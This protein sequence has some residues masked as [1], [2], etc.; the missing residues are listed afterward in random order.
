M[1]IALDTNVLLD[2][3]ANRSGAESAKKL[4]MAIA[5]EKAEGVISA[6]TITDIYYIARKYIGDAACREFI[7]NILTVFDVAPVDGEACAVALNTPMEDFEDALLAVCAKREGAGYIATRDVKFIASADSP[8]KALQP[9]D[10]LEL[11]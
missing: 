4:I 5:E 3:A 8:V 1:K 2:A 11:L 10:I 6:N 9:E 7:W